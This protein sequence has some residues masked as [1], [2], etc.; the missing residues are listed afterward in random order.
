MVK[1][2]SG[3]SGM[4]SF[5]VVEVR[6][7]NGAVDAQ[8]TKKAAEMRLVGRTHRGAASKTLS[9]MCR[10]KKIKGA[11]SMTITVKETTQGSSGKELTYKARRVK[12][13]KPLTIGKGDKARTIEYAPFVSADKGSSAKTGKTTATK[14]KTMKRRK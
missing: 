7:Q 3:K 12:L 8:A 1:S 10:Y 5:T 11:C 6:G 9:A 14:S 13:A 4:R 2:S